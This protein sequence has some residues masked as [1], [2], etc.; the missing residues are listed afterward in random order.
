MKKI[1][2]LL[3]AAF[4]VLSMGACKKQLDVKNPNQP[5]SEALKSESGIMSYGLGV[6][7]TGFNNI[8]YYDG[9][10]GYFWA[11]AMGFQELMGD[12]IG[13]DIANEFMNQIGCPDEVILDDGTVL[14][15][16]IHLR[17]RL[18]SFV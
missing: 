17:A 10:N 9:V 1:F 8:K 2:F 15:N 14:A 16:P 13:T 11:G 3:S 4:V 12:V 7:V 6:Y 18:I 5:S